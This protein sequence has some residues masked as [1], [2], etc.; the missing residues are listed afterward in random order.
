MQKTTVENYSGKVYCVT[1]PSGVIVTRYKDDTFIAGNCIHALLGVYLIKQI[2]KE[3]PEWFNDDF[4]AKLQRA[5]NKA[6]EAEAKIVDWIFEA[7]DLKFLNKETVKEFV[8]QR[9]NESLEMIGASKHF[10]VDA[11]KISDLKWF[12]DEIHA[13]VNTDFFHKKP[14][15]YSK[16]TKSF[17]AE[18]LF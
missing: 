16:F 8:K 2:Q 6:Y 3:Y 5:C 17:T 13:E 14:V 4:Y 7:G 18:D 1:V 12:E 15:T 11:K 10:E 9:F